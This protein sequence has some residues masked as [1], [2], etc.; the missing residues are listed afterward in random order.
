VAEVPSMEPQGTDSVAEGEIQERGIRRA[1]PG[2]RQ[3]VPPTK[4]EPVEYRCDG[5]SCSCNS[6]SDCFEL[7]RSGICGTRL[8][9]PHGNNSNCSCSVS[10]PF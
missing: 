8:V 1:P 3:P 10:G 7:G 2:I 4:E 5:N 6:T 9:C